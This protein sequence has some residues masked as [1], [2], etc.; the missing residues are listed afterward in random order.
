MSCDVIV[1]GAGV[2]GTTAAI[3][4]R[5]RDRTVT[6]VDRE[7][8]AARSRPRPDW[9]TPPV[10]TI[11]DELQI[12]RGSWLGEPLTGA[13]F[14][15]ADLAKSACSDSA[16]PIAWHIDYGALLGRL[17]D[18]AAAIGVDCIDEATPARIDF[19]E[20][21][22][23]AAFDARAAVA[24]RFLVYADGPTGTLRRAQTEADQWI[25]EARLAAGAKAAADHRMHWIL[26]LDGGETLVYWW[27][28]GDE[29]VIRLHA[30]GRRDD[31]LGRL[32]TL[33]KKLSDR[34]LL[35][36][37]LKPTQEAFVLRP[38]PSASAL[39]TESHVGKR[40]LTIGD[41]G[42]F[43]G[44]AG[45]HGIYPAI[46][47]ARLAADVLADAAGSPHP[48]DHLRR[49]SAEWRTRMADYLRPPNTDLQFLLPLVFANQ[50]MADRLAAA[51]YK[52][53]NI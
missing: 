27:R 2:A 8:L 35:S 6:L 52:G 13:V 15:R 31:V 12:E 30:G 1:I 47:S 19:G 43:I 41:A 23:T 4:L 50:Q 38:S 29:V 22:V 28:Y 24:S 33:L 53:E 44:A 5:G 11:L 21:S 32:R 39:E 34:S 49:F 51:L 17:H 37:K 7:S 18:R 46:W 40:S 45:R 3:S 26:G 36:G 16:E 9:I 14:H 48:Q 10:L 25:A 42:G 20:Q